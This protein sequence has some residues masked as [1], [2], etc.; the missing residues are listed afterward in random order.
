MA[1]LLLIVSVMLTALACRPDVG[2]D[3]NRTP[4]QSYQPQLNPSDFKNGFEWQNAYHF[5]DPSKTYIYEG[6]S[7]EG[8]E[9]IEVYKHF[10]YDT[11]NGI[12]CG[13]LI[14]EL[15]IDQ[16][17]L[18]RTQEYYAE[19]TNGDIWLLGVAV[20]NYNA[21]GTLIN[22]HGSWRSGESGAWPGLKMPAEPK[23]GMRYREEY[24]FNVAENQAE[25]I[26]TTAIV[27]TALGI[28]HNCVVIHEWSDLEPGIDEHNFYA[29]G[30]GLI[31]EYNLTTGEEMI[32]V[33][34]R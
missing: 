30:V 21:S 28:Y 7:D 12:P 17:L 29:P 31:R 15:Q 14:E 10:A 8:F 25:I 3:P 26:Q 2:I 11:I 27:Q 13:V 34:I 22:R 5:P 18:E 4:D 9:R 23:I 19:R 6:Y 32:L 1:R 33:E 20:E 16:L 24:L